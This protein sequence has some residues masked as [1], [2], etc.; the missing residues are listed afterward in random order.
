ML[1]A[2]RAEEI[3][4]GTT[5]VGPHRDDVGVR[6]GAQALRVFGSRGQL[7]CAALALRLAE[8]VLMQQKCQDSVVYLLDDCMSELD[9]HREA[10]LWDHL[11]AR[12]QVLVTGDAGHWR[13]GGAAPLLGPPDSR[14][15]SAGL[16]IAAGNDLVSDAAGH[17][18]CQCAHAQVSPYAGVPGGHGGAGL[19]WCGG[20]R[21][22][23]PRTD[24]RAS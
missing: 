17:F 21:D 18:L 10:Y 5:L 22:R 23:T 6:L 8:G 12:D 11:A 1:A 2:R 3:Q 24:L 4:R 7:R 13:R 14:W 20:A 19:G 9:P 15:A 16:A